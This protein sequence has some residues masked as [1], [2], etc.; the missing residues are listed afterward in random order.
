MNSNLSHTKSQSRQQDLIRA[1]ESARLASSVPSHNR[2][3]RFGR[4]VG[5]LRSTRRQASAPARSIARV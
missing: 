5:Q 3:A 4:A 2:V 1:A